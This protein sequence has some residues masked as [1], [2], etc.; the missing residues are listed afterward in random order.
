MTS[1]I[2]TLLGKS[3][4]PE[5]GL[6]AS[7]EFAGQPATRNPWHTDHSAGASSHRVRCW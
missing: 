2:V 3:T 1:L 7:T 5:F 6:T 4:P